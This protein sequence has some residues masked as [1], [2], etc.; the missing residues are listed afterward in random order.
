MAELILSICINMN[1]FNSVKLDCK[2]VLAVMKV[3]SNLD[4]KAVGKSHGEIGLGQ[5]RPEF[6]KCASFDPAI[7][8]RCSISYMKQLK[9][10]FG[11]SWPTFYNLGPNT[12]IKHPKLWPYYKKV[13]KVKK[14][15][16]DKYESK[17]DN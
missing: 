9:Q 5:L 12:K 13:L 4:P 7:N 1:A 16:S 17:G 8:T 3:E 14:E 11:S 6:H 10:R 15:F 2:T